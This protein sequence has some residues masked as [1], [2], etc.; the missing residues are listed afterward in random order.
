MEY[1]Y[2]VLCII[3]NAVPT[4]TRYET[5]HDACREQA[6]V[7]GSHVFGVTND[8]NGNEYHRQRCGEPYTVTP[9]TR[10]PYIEF[11]IERDL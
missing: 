8:L 4:L 7:R 9:P 11:P 5:Q 6:L 3:I 1:A 10:E 2:F